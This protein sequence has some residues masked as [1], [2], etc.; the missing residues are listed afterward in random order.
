MITTQTILSIIYM[1]ISTFSSSSC[2]CC[3][4]SSPPRRLLKMFV[5]GFLPPSMQWILLS[6]NLMVVCCIV[7]IPL[8]LADASIPTY[9]AS[10][11]FMV[12]TLLRFLQTIG[13]GLEIVHIALVGLA[14][15]LARQSLSQPGQVP[16]WVKVNNVK[17]EKDSKQ[18]F[19][20]TIP[21]FWRQV[22]VRVLDKDKD[23]GQK[24]QFSNHLPQNFQTKFNH[25]MQL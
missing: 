23:D 8:L 6:H 15:I 18:W 4:A 14:A 11:H 21:H 24:T 1:F 2:C 19:N 9:S 5:V 25:A 22:K 7:S 13:V 3:V 17:K 12:R 20:R 16:F 10:G